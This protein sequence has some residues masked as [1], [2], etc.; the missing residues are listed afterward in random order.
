MTISRLNNVQLEGV[1]QQLLQHGLAGAL[2][3]GTRD[4]NQ[5]IFGA[6]TY[7]QTHE[8]K[9]LIFGF[10]STLIW[11]HFAG[12]A[13]FIKCFFDW[14]QKLNLFQQAKNKIR[15]L[16]FKMLTSSVGNRTLETSLFVIGG[17][18]MVTPAEFLTKG[19]TCLPSSSVKNLCNN[20]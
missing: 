5:N 13:P 1:Q 17:R 15:N 4:F 10:A 20:N 18:E 16:F 3:T 2:R 7:L 9:I 12:H 14:V 8:R 11:N 6:R 19:Y